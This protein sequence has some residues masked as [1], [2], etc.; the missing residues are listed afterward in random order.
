[1]IAHPYRSFRAIRRRAIPLAVA[2]AG[3]IAGSC[4]ACLLL[5]RLVNVNPVTATA[6]AGLVVAYAGLNAIGAAVLLHV[7]I[8]PRWPFA[9]AGGGR[10]DREPGHLARHLRHPQRAGLS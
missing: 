1:V 9:A 7:A 2:N 4:L 3:A 10:H 5:T 8:G 6:L